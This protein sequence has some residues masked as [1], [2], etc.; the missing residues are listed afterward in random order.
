MEKEHKT[1]L[2]VRIPV[3]VEYTVLEKDLDFPTQVDIKRVLIQTERTGRKHNIIS[4]LCESTLLL[5][6]DDILAQLEKP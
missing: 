4:S 6:E 5:L 3:V 1:E 2:E